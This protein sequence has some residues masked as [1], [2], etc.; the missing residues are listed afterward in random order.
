MFRGN[1]RDKLEE[2]SEKER[3]RGRVRGPRQGQWLLGQG[4]LGHIER[5]IGK[6]WVKSETSGAGDDCWSKAPDGW[7]GLG[8]G[9]RWQQQ[10][11]KGVRALLP[12]SKAG[13][14][15]YHRC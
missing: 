11:W 10:L 14:N 12:P 1:D 6:P 2:G 7:A 3:E 13:R 9:H 8:M 5:A 4:D 15:R